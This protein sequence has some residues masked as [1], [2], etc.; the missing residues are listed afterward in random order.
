MKKRAIAALGS[1]V[2]LLGSCAGTAEVTSGKDSTEGKS[3]S[4]TMASI[5]AK[6][7]DAPMPE[8][9]D[10]L[11]QFY[12]QELNWEECGTSMDCTTMT[13]PLNYADPQGVTIELKI[14]RRHA[15]GE[16]IGSLL[17]NPG[18]PG[19][20]GQEMAESAAQFFTDRITSS[21]DIIGFDPRGVGESTPVDCV[22]DAELD[23]YLAMTYPDTPE[24]REQSRAAEVEYANKCAQNSGELVKYSGTEEAARDMDVIRH[25]VGDPKLY[26]VGFSYGTSLG[27]MYAQLFPANVGR[28]IL[29]GAV[30]SDVSQYEQQKP[31]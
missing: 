19:G 7:I 12:T 15:E 10:G 20:G 26:Y 25:L 5:E 3:S 17:A 11:E 8:I 31:K 14:K 18:G 24:G 29:D 1:A 4:D 13:V 28:V 30:D 23:D 22:S 27:G 6:A 2:L 9:P 16:K 21:F